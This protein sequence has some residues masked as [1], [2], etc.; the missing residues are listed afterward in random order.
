MQYHRLICGR[1]FLD[2]VDQIHP[3]LMTPPLEGGGEKDLHNPLGHVPP[4]ERT[5]H[6]TVIVTML[7]KS[8]MIRLF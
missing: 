4:D 6:M 5:P 1:F 8:G 2:G 7:M 3:A